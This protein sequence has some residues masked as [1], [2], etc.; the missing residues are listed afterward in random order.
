MLRVS[1]PGLAQSSKIVRSELRTTEESFGSIL[2][3][4]AVKLYPAPNTA[5]KIAAA[6]GCSPRNIELCL[7]GRQNWSGDAV[8]IFLAEICRRHA[9]RNVRIVAK[10]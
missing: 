4:I 8:A 7:S 10:G 2:T 6:V 9:M 1:A 5:A 3:E